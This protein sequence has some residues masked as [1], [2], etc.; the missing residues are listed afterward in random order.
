MSG[1]LTYD[2]PDSLA[3]ISFEQFPIIRANEVEFLAIL[4]QLGLPNN[5]EYTNEEKLLIYRE[6]KKLALALE[7]AVRDERKVLAKNLAAALRKRATRSGTDVYWTTAGFSRWGNVRHEITA[8]ALKALVAYDIDDELIPGVLSYFARTKQGKRWNSTKSTAMVLFAM[9]DYL[10]AREDAGDADATVAFRIND[11]AHKINLADGATRTLSFPVAGLR[12]G[13]NVL[14][15]TT[16]SK[17]SMFR[18]VFRYRKAGTDVA[19]FNGGVKVRRVFHLLDRNGNLGREI[20]PGDSIP[21]GSYM[22][23]TVTGIRGNNANMDY[24]FVE[25]PKPSSCEIV[26]ADDKRF[27]RYRS[28]RHVLREDKTT[29]VVHHHEAATRAVTDYCVFYAELAGEYT[30]PP[31]YCE[32]MYKPDVRG[33]SGT[34][35]FKVT[36]NSDQG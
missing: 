2:L 20:K 13:R 10:A 28:S 16:A 30:V 19:E 15:F 29:V 17:M 18:L 33:H 26:P 14:R 24:F 4:K 34:F 21:R 31:A 3:S 1:V 5:T 36:D 6:H 12:E 27:K 22:R 9:C 8:A 35:R 7:M 11:D 32:L 25:S 23:C